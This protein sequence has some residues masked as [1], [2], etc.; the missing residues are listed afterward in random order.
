MENT[1]DRQKVVNCVRRKYPF[2]IAEIAEIAQVSSATVSRVLNNQDAVKPDLREKVCQALR[3]KGVD[4]SDVILQTTS[5]GKLILFTLPF[6]FNS[7]FNDVIRGAKASAAQHGYQMLI[8]QEHINANTYPSFE[9][10]LKNLKISGLITLNHIN[11]A[12][13]KQLSHLLPIVQCCDYDL[14]STTVSSVNFDD[15][16]MAC[17]ATDHLF[18]LGCRRVAFMSGPLKYSD[19][20]YRKEGYLQSLR[21]NHVEPV[22]NWVIHLPEI[23]YNMAFSAATQL[24]SQPTRPDAFL[25][26]SD[27]FACAIINAARRLGLSVPNDLMVIGYDNVD[28]S[29]IS[30]PTITTINTPKFQFGYTA[31]ELLIEKIQIPNAITQHISLPSELII[32]ESTTLR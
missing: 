31:C 4:P 23:N 19:N 12:L 25:A 13:L 14:E 16:K 26:I 22:P 21:M 18:S 24:L 6:D 1:K 32:R 3:E 29:M 15:L 5:S 27:L 9:K 2:S 7:F 11:A 8:L 20:Y 30:S 28:Y 10:T 17:S